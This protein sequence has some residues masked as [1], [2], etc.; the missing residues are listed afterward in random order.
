[1]AFP[2]GG[3]WSEESRAKIRGR[4]A[5]NKGV[6]RTAQEIENIKAGITNESRLK[7]SQRMKQRWESGEMDCFKGN[8]NVSKRP[9]V[10]QK[11]GEANHK[12]IVTE[13]TRTKMRIARTG[14]PGPVVS[15]EIKKKH[16][17]R[18]KIN[19]PLYNLEILKRHPIFKS[20]RYHFSLGE[21][22]LSILLTQIG[23]EFKHQEP[24][25]KDVGFY[26][27]DF[28][29]VFNLIAVLCLLSFFFTNFLR[30]WEHLK[31]AAFSAISTANTRRDDVWTFTYRNSCRK[32]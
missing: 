10:A 31:Y 32:S 22:K 15:E 1:M 23:I 5:W 19:N 6:P 18:M 9:E 16:S 13:E 21:K 27:L 20:G 14:K 7:S 17:E 26:V 11:I 3:K 28:F 30:P 29:L 2:K 25:A 12:R 4:K 24:R 8:G